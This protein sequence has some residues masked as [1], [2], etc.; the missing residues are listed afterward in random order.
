MLLEETVYVIAKS[1]VPTSNVL[2]AM[3]N[4][5]VY[6]IMYFLLISLFC[7]VYYLCQLT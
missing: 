5:T 6:D 1:Q 3:C 4:V 2:S 7:C